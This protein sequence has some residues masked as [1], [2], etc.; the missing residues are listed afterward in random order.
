[1]QCPEFKS[2]YF[3]KR[4]NVVNKLKIKWKKL[5]PLG[6]QGNPVKCL[7]STGGKVDMTSEVSKSCI[8]F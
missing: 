5:I 7:H 1:V 4:K 3:Q 6:K 2:Q 8:R